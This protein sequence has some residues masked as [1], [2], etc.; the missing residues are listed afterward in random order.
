MAATQSVSVDLPEDLYARIRDIAERN[1]RS[2]EAV[3][4]ESLEVL[5][6]ADAVT[7]A[8]QLAQLDTYRDDQLWA[9]VYQRMA[10]PQRE[11]LRDLSASGK[12]GSLSA[13][14]HDELALL[15]D[16]ADTYTLLRSHALQLLKQRGH[17]VERYLNLGV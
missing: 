11:R 15:V 8:N 1:E 13:T 2:V 9:V 12:H 10:W 17:D 7:V 6:R 16:Q 3:L 14:E 5:F 4:R